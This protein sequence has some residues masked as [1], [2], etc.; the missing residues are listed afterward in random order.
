MTPHRATRFLLI[1]GLA[2]LA[3]AGPTGTPA[4]AQGTS[5]SVTL[6]AQTPW[7]S[8]EDPVL[9]VTVLA[10]NNGF[11]PLAELEVE[12]AIGPNYASRLQYEA[13][14]IDGPSYIVNAERSRFRGKMEPGESRTFTVA[15]DLTETPGI[16]QSESLVY[17]ARISLLSGGESVGSLTTPLLFFFQD[18]EAPVLFSTWVELDA[19]VAFG[20]DGRL[21]DTGFEAA[22]TAGGSLGAPVGA[23]HSIQARAGSPSPVDVAVEPS[24]V[25]QAR[26][27]A[28]GYTRSDGTSVAAG[29]GGAATA[30]LFLS[31]LANAV[32]SPGAQ[33]VS[34]PFSGPSLP[35]MLAGGL[36]SALTRQVEIGD[37]IMRDAL[38]VAPTSSIARP[39]D[40]HLSPE[41]VSWLAT[42]GTNVVLADADAVERPAQEGGYA[43]PATAAL[44][45]TA[46]TTT[47]V[48]PDPGVQSLL[49][50][51]ELVADPVRGAQAILG[52]LAVIWKERP[53]PTAPE[54]RGLALGLDSS[55]PP[56][57]WE[58]LLTRLA[59]APFLRM[60][61]AQDLATG[62]NPAGTPTEL[63]GVSQLVLPVEYASRL[64]SLEADLDA[65]ASMLPDDEPVSERLQL[66]L[67]Y[68]QAGEFV[69]DG[70]G[71]GAWLDPVANTIH[72]AFRGTTPQ[73]EQIFTLTSQEGTIPLRMGDPGPIPLRVTVMLQ[74]SQFEFPEG[75]RREVVLERPDQ[76]LTF[77]VLAKAAGRNPIRIMVLSPSGRVISQ[78]D[79]VVQTTTVNTIALLVTG[80]AAGLLLLLY[81][82]RWLR[83]RT[84]S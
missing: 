18:P 52:E 29:E 50:R 62:V 42:R 66:D 21:V 65:Y 10:T 25:E 5:A 9:S 17:P 8:L 16:S 14:L 70:A 64:S 44:A 60:V 41:A 61:H 48:L 81:S 24:L 73:V 32:T 71:G 19:P 7:N 79:L 38:D 2:V 13:S 27:M 58:P 67:L 31:Q 84:S 74:S 28:A 53:V 20:P 46:G 15:L 12:L 80:A 77:P 3:T 57:I 23:L 33:A 78:Q 51:P 63:T 6:L 82:R 69:I 47:L 30:E 36:D 39:P 34:M 40:G 75:A 55:L 1:L 37:A 56:G 76:I 35:A 22:L 68:A 26:R 43:P 4:L 45:S 59:G 72:A 49:S 54:V 83:R 11:E